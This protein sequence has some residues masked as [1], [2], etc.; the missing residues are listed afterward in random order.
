MKCQRENQKVI[1][2][3]LLKKKLRVSSVLVDVSERVLTF[4]TRELRG[5]RRGKENPHS[6]V[7]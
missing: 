5:V 1:L 2:L 6:F 4:I 7:R 3:W